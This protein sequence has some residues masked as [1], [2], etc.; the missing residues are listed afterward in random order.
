MS[1]ARLDF[2]GRADTKG[3]G[4]PTDLYKRFAKAG[5]PGFDLDKLE[6]STFPD[7]LEYLLD[8][9]WEIRRR[10]PASM[11]VEPIT[12]DMIEIYRTRLLR[13]GIEME[14]FDELLL[15]WLDDIFLDVRSQAL[16]GGPP[17]PQPA[18][19]KH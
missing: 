7:E 14:P 15:G 19:T 8:W 3:L 6:M 4:T 13:R 1:A 18:P 12:M 10:T 2:E 5:V 17:K 16:T 11:G 9:Y